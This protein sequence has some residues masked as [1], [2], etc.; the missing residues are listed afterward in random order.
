MSRTSSSSKIREA[1]KASGSTNGSAKPVGV[2][3]VADGSDD[4]D[5][6]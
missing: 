2:L 3:A 5:E 6:D 4:S 1:L